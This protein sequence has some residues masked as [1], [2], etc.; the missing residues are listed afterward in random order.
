[1]PLQRVRPS[2]SHVQ[3]AEDALPAAGELNGDDVAGSRAQERRTNGGFRRDMARTGVQAAG[4]HELIVDLLTALLL[5][6][7]DGAELR[8]VIVLL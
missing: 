7:H 1:L 5:N 8:A 3:H 6:A 2:R 4:A